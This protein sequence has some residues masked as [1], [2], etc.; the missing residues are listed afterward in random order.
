MQFQINKTEKGM[1]LLTLQVGFLQFSAKLPVR[2][3]HRLGKS[4][5]E[6]ASPTKVADIVEGDDLP[7]PDGWGLQASSSG[8][9]LRQTQEENSATLFI[10]AKDLFDFDDEIRRVLDKI[11]GQKKRDMTHGFR[12]GASKETPADPEVEQDPAEMAST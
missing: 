3:A 11:L 8:L 5:Q 7:I 12:L 2:E 4:L 6:M 10:P 1:I 9:I